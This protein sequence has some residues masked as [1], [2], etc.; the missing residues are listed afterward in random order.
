MIAV[1][2]GWLSPEVVEAVQ[3]FRGAIYIEDGAVETLKDGRH[4][5][6][7][8]MRSY[9]IILI[10]EGGI[11]ACIRYLRF[12]NRSARIGGWAVAPK[13]RG[14]RASIRMALET[15]RLAEQ[16]GDT[17]GIATATV[18]HNSAG[19]LRRLGGRVIAR[20]YDANYRCEMERI[21]FSLSDMKRFRIAA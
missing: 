9:H 15:V 2:L 5:E 3:R 14:T 7:P 4:I 19:I 16:F 12:G 10:D 6:A 17:H 8:D 11:G 18:R 20:Y 13:F 1:A 21:E